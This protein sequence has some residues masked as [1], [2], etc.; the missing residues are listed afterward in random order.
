VVGVTNLIAVK[1][2][3]TA[4]REDEIKSG[5]ERALVRS[6]QID[7]SRIRVEVKGGHITLTGTVHSWAERQ[8]AERAAWRAPGVTDVTNKIEVRPV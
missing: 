3:V 2:S 5:I 4:P 6:A 1:P 8:E 7:A